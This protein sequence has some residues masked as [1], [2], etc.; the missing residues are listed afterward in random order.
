MISLSLLTAASVSFSSVKTKDRT[1][2]L[3]KLSFLKQCSSTKCSGVCVKTRTFRPV[4]YKVS[5]I[6]D[7]RLLIYWLGIKNLF[8]FLW[9]WV[10]TTIWTLLLQP[11]FLLHNCCQLSFKKA[12]LQIMLIMNVLNVTSAADVKISS[13]ED[14]S[15]LASFLFSKNYHVIEETVS[16]DVIQ[17]LPTSGQVKLQKQFQALVKNLE[18]NRIDMKNVNC[19]A[20]PDLLL[21]NKENFCQQDNNMQCLS[22]LDMLHFVPNTSTDLGDVVS[23][24]CPLMLANLHEKKCHD[25]LVKSIQTI[26]KKSKPSTGA[27][28]GFGILFVTL[29]SCCSLVGVIL[30]PLLN[31]NVYQTLLML[32]EGLAVGS[33]LGSAV[34][35]LIPQ[36]FNLLGENNEHDYLWKSIIIFGGIYLFFLSERFMKIIIQVKKQ[37]KQDSE[38]PVTSKLLSSNTSGA[39]STCCS[40][41][42][43]PTSE[44]ACVC[45]NGSA[46]DNS[47]TET[48]LTRVT[49]SLDI[50]RKPQSN[51]EETKRSHQTGHHHEEQISFKQGHDSAIGTVAWMIIFGD[52]LHNFIDGLSVGAAFSESILAGISISVAVV[53]EEFP[54][55]L[56]DFAVL[57]NA[58]M[59]M[60]QAL[61]Y[62]FLSACTCYIGLVFGILVGDLAEGSSYIFALAG[63]MFLYISLVDMMG[64]LN[65]AAEAATQEGLKITLR[66]LFLQNLGIIIGIVVL[67]VM[68]RYSE[69][70]NFD[71]A[72]DLNEIKIQV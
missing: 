44:G 27:V 20:F 62:N 29:I 7:E 57:L 35:H 32:F 16:S 1:S 12:M 52:G 15:R 54:H 66:V 40:V 8:S 28:W 25:G 34:F 21:P 5:C 2:S 46:G 39:S 11:S 30:L 45:S 59:T 26:Q 41:A 9:N 4:N 17:D 18:S 48:S 55:E 67:F 69:M 47:E 51:M 38:Q 36:A 68:A 50:T 10:L 22:A 53:C 63:G 42:V 37:K 31:K 23:Q 14:V 43:S 65:E 6:L 49:N 60:R 13:L 56:G 3:Q 19:S 33:L 70:I 71:A 24:I 64:E 61:M 58:G 72:G